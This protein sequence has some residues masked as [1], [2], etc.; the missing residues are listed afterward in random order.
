MGIISKAIGVTGWTA[1]AAAGTFVAMTRK[2]RILPVPASDYIFN[3]T[4][5]ARYNPYNSPVTQDICLRRVP[6]SQIKP[7]YLE[8]EGRLAEKFCAGVWSGLGYAYQRRYLEKKYRGP[9]TAGHLWDKEE[10]K[11]S[12]YEVGTLITDHF[13][14][15]AKTPESIM[16]RCGDS[17]RNKD[18]RESDGLFEMTAEIKKDE[19][20]AE[21]GLKSV[22]Y[23]GLS[24]YKSGS[25]AGPMPSHVQW[26]H[27]QYDKVL[28]E[29]A[30]V[31]VT[32]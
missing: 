7:E 18:A 5:Y 27:Q 23:N 22:F 32:K 1:F 11:E 31:N 6:L 10:L 2:N 8:Q 30:L 15:V 24:G 9:E 21:F 20:V 17:P 26:L 29:S 12:K 4:S 25:T 13:E 28:M 14:V 19:G 16:V 3:S